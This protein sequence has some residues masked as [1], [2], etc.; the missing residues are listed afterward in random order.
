MC[1]ALSNTPT[2]SRPRVASLPCVVFDIHCNEDC[3]LALHAIKMSLIN[4]IKCDQTLSTIYYEAQL[5]RRIH[6]I[7]HHLLLLETTTPTRNEFKIRLYING[8]IHYPIKH[9]TPNPMSLT[10]N[11]TTYHCHFQGY[12]YEVGENELHR[13]GG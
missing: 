8:H 10:N 7:H 2:E 1:I 3:L 11:I 5:E 13:S 9:Y 6:P 4:N 12:G